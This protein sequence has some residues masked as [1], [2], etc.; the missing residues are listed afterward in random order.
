MIS[1]YAIYYIIKWDSCAENLKRDIQFCNFY[2]WL[3]GTNSVN[4]NPVR[5]ILNEMSGF[6]P[7]LHSMQFAIEDVVEKWELY[8]ENLECQGRFTIPAFSR[9]CRVAPNE[10]YMRK[11]LKLVGGQSA[12][13]VAMPPRYRTTA[14]P[15]PHQGCDGSQSEKQYLGSIL[16]LYFAASVGRHS[17]ESTLFPKPWWKQGLKDCSFSG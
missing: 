5:K 7:V 9:Q 8:A 3:V 1:D 11:I 14:G 15:S 2:A 13:N 17:F 4:E 16:D 12:V 10:N 6:L